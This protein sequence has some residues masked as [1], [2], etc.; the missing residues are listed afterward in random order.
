MKWLSPLMALFI[1][2]GLSSAQAE[3]MVRV[4]DRAITDLLAIH[5]R[6]TQRQELIQAE[7]CRDHPDPG[8]VPECVDPGLIRKKRAVSVTV[9]T[10]P[11]PG[12]D[13]G[14]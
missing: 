13:A 4:A 6:E 11:S 10:V 2:L 7:V 12:E 3:Q 5:E 9:P 1:A 8:S 14:P